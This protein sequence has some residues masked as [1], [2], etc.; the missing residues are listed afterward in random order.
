LQTRTGGRY[1]ADDDGVPESD[2]PPRLKWLSWTDTAA[3]RFSVV[4]TMPIDKQVILPQDYLVVYNL[5]DG[6]EPANAYDCR[7]SCNRAVITF[8]DGNLLTFASV[9]GGLAKPAE[10]PFPDQFASSQVALA[11][12]TRRFQIVTSPVTYACDLDLHTL[13]RYWN[14]Q[15]TPTQPTTL[16][17]LIAQDPNKATPPASALLAEGISSCSFGYGGLPNTRSGLI[18]LDM[19]FEAGR[20]GKVKLVQQVHVD[21]TP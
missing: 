3:N 13:T 16:A 15:I 7:V 17:S 18:T 5:G 6:Q 4:G 21:N 20:S 12:P 2:V 8:I 1:L 11:S 9:N 10:N 19:T 14:Y